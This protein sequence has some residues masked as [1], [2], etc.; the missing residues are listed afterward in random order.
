ML[1][2][3]LVLVL[4]CFLIEPHYTNSGHQRP[5]HKSVARSQKPEAKEGD[6]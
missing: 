6:T 1:P 2:I 5:L 4:G 3:V